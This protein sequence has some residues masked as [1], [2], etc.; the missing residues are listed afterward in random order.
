M[1]RILASLW[2]NM[3]HCM[4]YIHA[5]H[6]GEIVYVTEKTEK[7]LLWHNNRQK[8]ASGELGWIKSSLRVKNSSAF[9]HS[10]KKNTFLSSYRHFLWAGS[11]KKKWLEYRLKELEDYRK[12][13]VF[14]TK[15]KQCHNGL[16]Q[17]NRSTDHYKKAGSVRHM[18]EPTKTN[19]ILNAVGRKS[20]LRNTTSVLSKW[21]VWVKECTY[22]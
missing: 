5:C 7:L 19:L 14:F 21:N 13:A 15:C 1:Q 6:Q 3:V 4:Q 11:R 16:V 20:S 22:F 8:S 9:L 18:T 12:W 17:E 10:S 2:L